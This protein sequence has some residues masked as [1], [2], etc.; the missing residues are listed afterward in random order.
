MYR[1]LVGNSFRRAQEVLGEDPL[2]S[3]TQELRLNDEVPAL[4]VRRC[5]IAPHE[6]C[7]VCPISERDLGYILT[8]KR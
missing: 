6:Q 2:L 3:A 4:L 8:G 1:K 7:Y 5:V